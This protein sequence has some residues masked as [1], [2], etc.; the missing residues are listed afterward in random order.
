MGA[1]SSSVSRMEKCRTDF[2]TSRHNC[3]DRCRRVIFISFRYPIQTIP[4]PSAVF[5]LH[6]S[7]LPDQ[8]DICAAVS[9]TGTISFFRFCPD[10][11]SPALDHT[12]PPAVDVLKP[13]SVL[14][15]PGLGEDVLF[16]YFA[17]HPTI[18]GLMAVATAGGQVILVRARA[19]D[20]QA[21]DV[22][23]E[24]VLEHSLEAWVAAFSPPGAEPEAQ[25]QH[26]QHQHPFTIFSGGDDSALKYTTYDPSPS[27][28]SSDTPTNTPYPPL[29]IRS[30]NAGVTSILPLPFPPQLHPSSAPQHLVLTG[31]YDDH[32]RLHAIHPPHTTHG[33]RRATLLAE[34][35][36]GGGVWRLNLVRSVTRAK[37][38]DNA[39]DAWE[40]TVLASCMHAGARVVRVRGRGEE[41]VGDVEVLARFEEHASMNYGSDWSRSESRLAV[42]GEGRAGEV[43]C[44]STSF[45]DR[46][47]CVWKFS[48]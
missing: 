48:L 21:L 26:H 2:P 37:D 4:Q 20:Y 1:S 42:D 31:S 7:P 6:F 23:E 3:L 30:H 27:S 34:R 8:G 44:V 33:A 28:P 36:L 13:L 12:S 38:D 9:S 29:T 25:H 5:D 35:D 41:V 15:I 19:E 24:S 43:L 14:R 18:P 32:L 17:W 45:Y 40:V 11:D 16:T 39:A 10:T 47:L 22:L 46:L